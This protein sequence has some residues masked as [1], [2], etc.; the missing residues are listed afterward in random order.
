MEDSRGRQPPWD[1]GSNDYNDPYNAH[2]DAGRGAWVGGNSLIRLDFPT[3]QIVRP[4]SLF[5]V[6]G[7]RG[8]TDG[9]ILT[10][11]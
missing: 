10:D 8:R 9:G 5:K 2:D 7:S 3:L 6:P 11:L 1:I 4:A